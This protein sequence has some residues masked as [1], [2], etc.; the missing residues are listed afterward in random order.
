[1]KMKTMLKVISLAAIVAATVPSAMAIPLITGVP[2]VP[3]PT[4]AAAAT[5]TLVGT[6]SGTV[7]GAHFT[8]S[9]TESVY[10]DATGDTVGGCT[11]G[12]GC[13]DF[14]FNFTN[15]GL[16]AIDLA[17]MDVFSGFLVDADVIA[18]PGVAPVDVYEN[19]NGVINWD[20]NPAVGVGAGLASQTLVLYTNAHYIDRNGTFGLA[21]GGPGNSGDLE[22][23]IT[24]EPSSLLL[25]GTGLLTAVGAAR[26]K[27]KA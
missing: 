15:N 17:N 18:G 22:P 12:S 4:T 23:T 13:L 19:I 10:S 3:A 9:W 11:P 7:I 2:A 8:A 5:G 21:D 25:L 1:M 16:D 24:P 14:V 26:R 6:A 20:Y 27:F